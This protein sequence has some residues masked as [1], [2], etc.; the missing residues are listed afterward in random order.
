MVKI[1]VYQ[2]EV[3]QNQHTIRIKSFPQKIIFDFQTSSMKP[4]VLE[5]YKKINSL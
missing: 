3:H 1:N 5:Y 2:I 4:K